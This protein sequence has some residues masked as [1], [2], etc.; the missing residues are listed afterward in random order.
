[1][2]P[3]ALACTNGNAA[4]VKLLL[5]AGAD[6][7]ATMK[8]GETVLMMA[9]R[10]GSVDA[11]KALLVR[12]AKHDMRE[13]HGQT[14]L[15]WAAAEGHAA[16]VRALIE[17][18]ADVNASLDSGF[19]AFFFAVREGRID[20]ARALLE[21]GST[22][23]RR[24]S[25]KKGPPT[26]RPIRTTSSTGRSP[27]ARPR[28]CSR[29]R[30]ATSSSRSRWSTPVRIR[31]MCRWGFSPLHI[32]SVGQEAGFQRWQRPV[33][34]HRVGPSDQ[35]AIRAGDREAGRDRQSASRQGRA[36]VPRDVLADRHRRGRRPF[37][38][39]PIAPIFR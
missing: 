3:L 5:D 13:G 22:S 36:E 7:N 6:A 38:W 11:V 12:G 10:A 4:V 27:G 18:G 33:D 8:G 21:K 30:T 35:P 34:A 31:T 14:A 2:P 1:M 26:A 24:F 16:V 37:F 19:T 39:P 28:C 9:A 32:L 25:A 17:A 20:A 29:C 15:M 23:T